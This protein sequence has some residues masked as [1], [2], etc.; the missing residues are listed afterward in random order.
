MGYGTRTYKKGK[1]AYKFAKK[2]QNTAQKALKLAQQLK[3]M[4]NVE[5]KLDYANSILGTGDAITWTGV[6]RNL[7]QPTQ[8]DG[9]TNRDGDS[10]KTLRL[11]GRLFIQQ[12][13]S[14][15][16]SLLRVIIF[17]GKNENRVAYAPSDF[18]QSAVGLMV[19]NGKEYENR[20]QTKTLFD[21]TYSLSSAGKS[22]YLV[23]MNLPLTG[24]I[25]FGTGSTDIENGG[26]Y[27][28][29][30]SN[31]QTNTPLVTYT[32]KTSFTDN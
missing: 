23:N 13:A 4:V 18:L 2:H 28:L 20:F 24:H 6:V 21:K 25:Q 26:I 29:L 22:N 32:L 14:A 10:I 16:D 19:L 5:Y 1:K 17:R 3:R 9:V 15:T 12:N 31:E 7:C 11:S 8:G 30:I 27:M